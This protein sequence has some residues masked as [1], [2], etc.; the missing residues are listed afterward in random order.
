VYIPL[1]IPPHSGH[2][3]PPVEKPGSERAF[4]VFKDTFR[5]VLK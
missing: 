4:S 1:V 5:E 3:T 2:G